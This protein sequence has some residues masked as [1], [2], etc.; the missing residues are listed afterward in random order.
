MP[1]RVAIRSMLRSEYDAPSASSASVAASTAAWIAAR[2]ALGAGSSRDS[3]DAITIQSTRLEVGP[4]VLDTVSSFWSDPRHGQPARPH[5]P[6]RRRDD[7]RRVEARPRPAHVAPSA[8]RALG[9]PGLGLPRD[10]L[11]AGPPRLG[12]DVRRRPRGGLVGAGQLLRRR[13]ARDH[14]VQRGGDGLGGPARGGLPPYAAGRRAPPR[15]APQ[16]PLR[17]PPPV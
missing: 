17:A 3:T 1:A 4:A 2:L 12:G 10:R 13:G 11:H 15:P 9:A 8:L 6:G 7:H 5:H 14:P 16:P